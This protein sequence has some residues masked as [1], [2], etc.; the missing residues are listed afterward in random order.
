MISPRPIQRSALLGIHEC[1]ADDGANE[2]GAG[3]E[4]PIGIEPTSSAW[5]AEVI[6][7]IRRSRVN[8]DTNIRGTLSMNPPTILGYQPGGC[9]YSLERASRD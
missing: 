5:K 4:R 2:G 8:R 9:A 1:C 6:A 3:S 7:I